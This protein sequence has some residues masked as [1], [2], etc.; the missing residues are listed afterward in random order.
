MDVEVDDQA[1]PLESL[2]MIA[3]LYRQDTD[4]LVRGDT[5]LTAVYGQSPVHMTEAGLTPLWTA[6]NQAEARGRTGRGARAK[7]GGGVWLRCSSG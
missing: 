6:R 5:S 1:G 2:S 4:A 7:V 3:R